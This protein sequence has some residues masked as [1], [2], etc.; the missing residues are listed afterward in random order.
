MQVRTT[1]ARVQPGQLDEFARRWRDIVAAHVPEVPGL[2]GAYLCGNRDSDTVMA[3]HL[4]ESPPAAAA[5]AIHD[6][7]RF[8]DQVQDL[9]AGGEP[10]VAA[11]EVLAQG[12]GR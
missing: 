3:I 9:L 11:Y 10:V 5:H 4:W 1:T 12:E 2:R 8:R 7:Q 6:R